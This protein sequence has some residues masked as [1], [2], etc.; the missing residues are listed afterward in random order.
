MSEIWMAIE[1]SPLHCPCGST[2]GIDHAMICPKGGFSTLRQN[3][4]RDI[5]AD[6]LSEIYSDVAVEPHLH[7][8]S[9]ESLQWRTNSD[10]EAQLDVSARGVWQRGEC[11]LFDIRVF[12]HNTS[13]Y[14]HTN[15]QQVYRNHEQEK[16]CA[17]G[18]RVTEIE[19][20][21]F[22][23]LVVSSTGGMGKEA[24]SECLRD[25]IK[26]TLSA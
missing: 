7:L 3:K 25:K 15:L 18:E 13:S 2:F 10:D 20:G 9:G 11:A 22:T 24:N 8:L 12:Y 6:L 4:V 16:R 19:G 5:T 21:S 17:Y 1:R 26:T 14:R 23:P